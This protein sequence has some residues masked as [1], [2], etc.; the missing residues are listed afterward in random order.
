MK[1]F[2]T[3]SLVN[4]LVCL[5]GTING[6]I[7]SRL[8]A[9]YTLDGGHVIHVAVEAANQGRLTWHYV[10]EHN[11]TVVFDG[12]D[13]GTTEYATYGDA[14][15]SALAFLTL[16]PGDVDAEYFDGY[17][18]AQVAWRDMHAEELSMYG[19]EADD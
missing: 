14:A 8:M 3:N 12:S 6:L 15:R 13:L 7:S 10:L 1:T 16:R 4:P 17:T 19:M 9:A 18:P 2:P 11:G 5:M